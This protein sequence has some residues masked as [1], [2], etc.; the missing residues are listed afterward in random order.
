MQTLSEKKEAVQSD[1]IVSIVSE[2][3]FLPKVIFWL[4]A[5]TVIP[6]SAFRQMQH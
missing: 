3:F 2:T 1:Y 4:I 5:L 6:L